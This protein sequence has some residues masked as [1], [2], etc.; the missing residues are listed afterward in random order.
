MK[1]SEMERLIQEEMEKFAL[2]QEQGRWRAS[3][4][5]LQLVQDLGM[6]PP[7]SGFIEEQNIEDRWG[8]VDF[9]RTEFVR[10]IKNKWEPEDEKK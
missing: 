2:D 8:V 5:I 7:F 10:V 1:R 4:E 6:Q 9:G 3:I